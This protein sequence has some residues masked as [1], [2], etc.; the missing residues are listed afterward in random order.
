VAAEG[1]GKAKGY[2]FGSD[3]ILDLLK[4]LEG[5]F[6]KERMT[7][8]KE[9]MDKKHSYELLLQTW[10]SQIAGAEKTRDDKVASKLKKEQTKASK[11]KDLADLKKLSEDD[12]K[13]LE[14]VKATCT[15]KAEDF[16]ERQGLRGEELAAIDKA[17]DA[18]RGTVLKVSE[19]GKSKKGTAL[20][21]LRSDISGALRDRAV[22]LLRQRA[23]EL[24]SN[25]LSSLALRVEGDGLGKIKKMI[26]SLVNRLQEEAAADTEK[27][28]WCKKELATNEQARTSKKQ[29][30]DT[31]QGE[32]DQLEV[33]ITELGD[34][35]EGL[36]KDITKLAA[37]REE[38]EKL[39]QAEK[40]E[41]EETIKDAQDAQ[42][43]I[44]QAV[45]ALD[46]FYSGAVAKAS[47]TALLQDSISD[48]PDIFE[49]SYTG[50]DGGGVNALLEVL[51]ADFARL[52]TETKAAEAQSLGEHTKFMSD[53]KVDKAA[54]EKEVELKTETKNQ[55]ANQLKSKKI[56]L[57]DAGKALAAANKYL[58]E[59]KPECLKPAMTKEEKMEQRK[60][61]IESL[62]EVLEILQG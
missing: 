8:E 50:M 13:Y 47:K 18:I 38:S 46:S 51:E 43:A 61:E 49:G 28:G 25:T 39:R 6:K 17:A 48:A 60:Q 2:E 21:A 52:E 3:K 56:D 42:K 59:L 62:K 58:E 14:D 35:V 40:E 34:S 33:D 53:S 1:P 16:K 12:K 15:Q 5:K 9:E 26:S 36:S 55:K 41:N 4:K 27:D 54:K 45:A 10:K 57:A 23:E 24:D 37:D 20:A 7:M 29:Q 22:A 44:A 11:E 32:V 30:M 19:K 31:L